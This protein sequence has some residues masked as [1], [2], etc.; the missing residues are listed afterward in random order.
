VLDIAKI[1]PELALTTSREN[2][3]MELTAK[4]ENIENA[5]LLVIG[6]PI[7]K[8]SYTGLLKHL[9]DLLN[10]SKSETGIAII[11]AT[12][13][14]D[15]NALTLEYSLRPLLSQTGYYTVPTMVYA[16]DND[17]VDFRVAEEAV[18]VRARRAVGEAFRILGLDPPLSTLITKG[19]FRDSG[20]WN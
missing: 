2:A 7:A 15:C 11:T 12:D 19:D 1:A 14:D 17:F 8:G 10:S 13:R 9:F 20:H 16:R 4:L 6:T 3:R 18:I 5:D